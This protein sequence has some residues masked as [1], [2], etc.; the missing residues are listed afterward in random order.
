MSGSSLQQL[1]KYV[2]TRGLAQ[3]LHTSLQDGITESSVK[4]RY[5]VYVSDSY[6]QSHQVKREVRFGDMLREV[7]S[8]STICVLVA[9]GLLS[10]FV[11]LFESREQSRLEA[12]AVLIAVAV[13][14]LVAVL[15]DYKKTKQVYD[16]LVRLAKRTCIVVRDGKRLEIDTGALVV[17][18]LLYLNIG[19][20]LPADGIVVQAQS[21]QLDETS[22]T[23]KSELVTK[24]PF[25]GVRCSP[26]LL[27][28]TQ[29]QAGSGFMLVCGVDHKPADSSLSLA[30]IEGES[31]IQT[32]LDAA[33]T[34]IGMPGL[35]SVLSI[36]A[37]LMLHNAYDSYQRGAVDLQTLRGLIDSL[38][39]A[40]ALVSVVIPDSTPLT[41]SLAFSLE[42]MLAEGNQVTSIKTCETLGYVTDVCT[43][44]A[45]ALTQNR[46]SVTAAY[47]LDQLQTGNDKNI[48]MHDQHLKSLLKHHFSLCEAELQ[49]EQEERIRTAMVSLAERWWGPD[50]REVRST[51]KVQVC[52]PFT[53]TRK[54]TASVV[55]QI[56][57]CYVYYKGS[58]KDLLQVCEFI[59][60]SKGN[61]ALGEEEKARIYEEAHKLESDPQQTIGLAYKSGAFESGD[62]LSGREAKQDFI[63]RDLVFLG[64]LGF[65]DPVRDEVPAAVAE[66]QQA[67]VTVRMITEDSVDT[68]VSIAKKCGIVPSDFHRE[69]SP[70]IV[71]E[72]RQFEAKVGPLISKDQ[73]YTVSNLSQF[74]QIASKLRVLAQASPNQKLLLVA[75]LQQLKEH[76]VL[77][78]GEGA[79]DASALQ[80][81]DVSFASNLTDTQISKEITDIIPRNDSF[82]N[83]VSVVKWG[84]NVHSFVTKAVRLQATISTVVLGL[85][86]LSAVLLGSALFS[87]VQI[88]WVSLLLDGF[89]VRSQAAEPLNS[90]PESKSGS[91]LSAQMKAA[92]AGTALYQMVVLAFLLF[93]SPNAFGL[94]PSWQEK[95]WSEEGFQHFTLCFHAFVLMQVFNQLHCSAKQSSGSFQITLIKLLAQWLFI[96]FGGRAF[97]CAQLSKDLHLVS[98][99]AGAGV[100]LTGPLSRLVSAPESHSKQD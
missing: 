71:L 84:R 70:S 6:G 66:L 76:T 35:F 31:D 90:R 14:V 20:L 64:V 3:R 29:V 37:T 59:Y 80:Q 100:L 28:G 95:Q 12:I 39:L 16:L 63:R 62:F 81:A 74:T 77:V 18:D 21:L 55:D 65:Q 60:D 99:L 83:V 38:L 22:I 25:T 96:N 69:S 23:G 87:T 7:M 40:T 75:G 42:Q 26:F 50:F 97:R 98:I 49:G 41:V 91:L 51:Y 52:V 78:V 73:H 86:L 1:A 11:G 82:A 67:G 72:G 89:G 79:A 10:L 58:V 56:D 46:V 94:R 48:N 30:Q 53:T 45:G 8:D 92:V 68:A 4:D 34:Q 5:E 43:G 44:K 15:N 47:F 32:K 88:L 13:V 36:V 33:M 27:F 61:R 57:G 93:V 85:N 54:W 2:G 19:M 17:G 24:E 9:M